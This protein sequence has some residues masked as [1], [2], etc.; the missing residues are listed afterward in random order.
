MEKTPLVNLIEQLD[1]EI[2]KVSLG[3]ITYYGLLQAK[4]LATEF[5]NKEKSTIR[6]AFNSGEMNVWNKDRNEE[7]EY[8]GGEDYFN[9]NYNNKP[10]ENKPLWQS[11]N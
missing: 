2:K 3:G 6:D 11:T 5:I 9:K 8:E 4:E 1:K 7:F 10:Q